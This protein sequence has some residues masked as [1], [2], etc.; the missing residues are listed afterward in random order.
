MAATLNEI[1][2]K[3]RRL[4]RSP[5]ISQITVA[6]LDE[7]INTFI[8]YDFPEHL[9]LF[10]S[11]TTF[12]FY[13][14]P[15][16]DLYENSLVPGTDFFNFKDRYITLHKPVYID[17]NK[18]LFT[19]SL[20][21]FLN[22]YPRISRIT[23]IGTGDGVQ[24]NFAGNLAPLPVLANDVV[25][26]SIDANN[27]GLV[28]HDDGTGNLMGDG[29]GL[30]NYTTGLYGVQFNV[31]PGNGAEVNVHTVPYI[32]ARPQSILYFDNQLTLRPVP[33]QPYKVEM[34]AYVRPT[35]LLQIGDSPEL[36]QWWQYIAYGAAK[37]IF[38]DRLDIESVALIM[39]EF[40]AQEDLVLRR[41]IVQQTKERVATI[42]TE[43]GGGMYGS[44]WGGGL[45]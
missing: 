38:E 41:T 43:Q 35:E 32:A 28:V 39:P 3:V 29:L 31:A 10:T 5:S 26:T 42:F 34:E 33:D 22:I 45:W 18:A 12:I 21:Q 15:N 7:Y 19:Q 16:R 13:T 2:I 37:K 23:Q 14:D 17:G 36:E 25:F 4:T 44:G 24:V 9:R 40:K 20:E 11:R 8:L 1:R 6:E 27:N 30:V